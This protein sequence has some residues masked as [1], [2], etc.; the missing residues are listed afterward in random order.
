MGSDALIRRRH[1]QGPIAMLG[2]VVTL[3]VT[4]C[5]SAAAGSSG[6]DTS[7]TQTK[8]T[9]LVLMRIGD[10]RTFTRRTL[11]DGDQIKCVNGSAN[12]AVTIDSAVWLVGSSVETTSEGGGGGEATVN[13]TGRA[14]RDHSAL[15]FRCEP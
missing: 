6:Q 10:V 13:L 2:L 14:S 15:R 12:A 4:G 7:V 5:G 3:I 9:A 8:P 11:K 1:L